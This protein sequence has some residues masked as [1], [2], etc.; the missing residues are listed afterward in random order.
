MSSEYD[1]FPPPPPWVRKQVNGKV[2]YYNDETQELLN[3]HPFQRTSDELTG[4]D[5]VD[6]VDDVD[7]VEDDEE[8]EEIED[9]GIRE[10]GIIKMDSANSLRFRCE[11][12]EIG[13]FGDRHCFGLTIQY[14]LK[15][16]KSLIKF[17][18]VDAQ[19]QYSVLEGPYGPVDRYDLF[20]GSRIKVLGRAVA[21]VSANSSACRWIDKEYL[22]L[23]KQQEFLRSRIEKLGAICVVVKPRWAPTV[24]HITRNSKN[25]GG[26]CDLRKVYVENT[27]LGEQISSLGLPHIY[28]E[29]KRIAKTGTMSGTA[30]GTAAG[31]GRSTNATW[32]K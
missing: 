2:L 1:H 26:R 23:C 20:V 14:S 10:G 12:K 27:R 9:Q 6:D 5:V 7:D 3:V 18:G 16:Q 22:K 29:S 31:T 30:A 17:D 15:D 8:S 21:I 24:F 4:S 25:S 28:E 19:W 13:L 11:W 32:R